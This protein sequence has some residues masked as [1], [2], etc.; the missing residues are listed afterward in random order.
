MSPTC[1]AEQ[2]FTGRSALTR[3]RGLQCGGEHHGLAIPTQPTLCLLGY[4][5]EHVSD[6]RL[7]RR[8]WLGVSEFGAAL[9]RGQ[10]SHGLP[11]YTLGLL[12][13]ER[14]RGIFLKPG[15]HSVTALA[16]SQIQAGPTPPPLVS[17]IANQATSNMPLHSHINSPSDPTSTV[18][19]YRLGIRL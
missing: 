3:G 18:S 12:G 8:T 1:S 19:K 11:Y 6:T 16:L 4:S 7:Y 13:A 14:L 15:V 10:Q 17:A 9:D 5:M 2:N